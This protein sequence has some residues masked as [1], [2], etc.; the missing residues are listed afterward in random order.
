MTLIYYVTLLLP[1]IMCSYVDENLN[2][3]KPLKIIVYAHIIA[4]KARHLQYQL[5][6]VH[7]HE[8]DSCSYHEHLIASKKNR[9]KL[10]TNSPK[11]SPKRAHGN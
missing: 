2:P 3:V 1:L 9:N 6:H 4:G 5:I 10:W 11:S 8:H 7:V